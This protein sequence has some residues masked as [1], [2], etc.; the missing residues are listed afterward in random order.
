VPTGTVPW[1]LVSK[2]LQF[3]Q[4]TSKFTTITKTPVISLD[5]W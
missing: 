1:F 4:V 2:F 5:V 3:R